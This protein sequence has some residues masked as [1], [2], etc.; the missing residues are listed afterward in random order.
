MHRDRGRKL[1]V[2]V[3]PLFTAAEPLM[4]QAP[5]S[6]QRRSVRRSAAGLI[7]QPRLAPVYQ[8][9][10]PRFRADSERRFRFATKTSAYC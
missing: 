3:E 9:Q 10:G 2:V 5:L 6:G 7:G 1:G 8:D 4:P